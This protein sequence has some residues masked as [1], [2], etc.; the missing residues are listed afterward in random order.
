MQRSS[1]NQSIVKVVASAES[2]FN[3]YLLTLSLFLHYSSAV[4]YIIVIFPFDYKGR[5]HSSLVKAAVIIHHY[6][7]IKCH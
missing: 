7:E 4:Y 2:L 3:I 5:H 1:Y 6:M